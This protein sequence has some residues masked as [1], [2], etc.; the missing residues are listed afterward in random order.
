MTKITTQNSRRFIGM[1]FIISIAV[2][3]VTFSCKKE[4]GGEGAI[5]ETLTAG[6]ATILVDNT[7]QP[8][9]EDVLA[10]F[11]NVYGRAA[12]AQ[13]NKT[14]TDIIRLLLADSASVAVLPRK[15][16]AEEEAHFRKKKITAEVTEFATDA[17]ALVTNEKATDTIIDVEEIIRVIKGEPSAKIQKLVFDNANSSTVQYLLKMAGV[18]SL[19]T[20]NVYALKTNEEVIKY[21]HDNSGAVG[22]I[23]LNWLLQPPPALTKYVENIT[24]LAVGNVNGNTVGKKYYKPNQSNLGAGLYPLARKV[25][26]LNYQAKL[27]LGMG[28][29]TYISAPEGQRIILKSGLLPN[30]IPTRELEVRKKL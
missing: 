24:V 8:V 10:V 25:Y 23:G 9:V 21:V 11:H 17:V 14:E 1:L 29:A 26:V 30:T 22:V 19:P 13:V 27:G 5:E 20:S 16:T 7:L 12:I 6:K 15:L 28:F 18:T 4:E 3:A 2:L